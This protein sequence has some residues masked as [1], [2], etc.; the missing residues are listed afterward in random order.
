MKTE[1]SENMT[2]QN[3]QY[4]NLSFKLPKKSK[5][6]QEEKEKYLLICKRKVEEFNT[7][8]RKATRKNEM[9]YKKAVLRYVVPDFI[10]HY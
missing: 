7:N 6:T 1:N 9:N 4:E 5:L 10:N 3:G 2:D 8:L